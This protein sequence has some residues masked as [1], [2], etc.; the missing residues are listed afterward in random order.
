MDGVYRNQRHVYDLTRKYYLLGRDRLLKELRPKGNDVMLEIACG[1][2]RNLAKARRLYPDTQMF[3]LD[4]S[5]QMLKSARLTLAKDI[6]A[7]RVQLA[8]GDACAFDPQTLFGRPSFDRIF[9]SY[10]LSMIPDWEGALEQA[11]DVLAP[12]GSLHVVDFG[13]QAHLPT[14][15]K[16]GLHTWLAKFH[17]TPRV[18]LEEA[19]ATVARRCGGT[20]TLTPLY[21]DYA[22][23]GTVRS[24]ANNTG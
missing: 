15:F 9:I 3:G 24:D 22:R 14:W 13:Q 2:G 4:I 19:L 5:S 12:G 16:N 8:Q 6:V 7:N 20:A 1:T 21:R 23:L 18:H 10:G 17:V 11:V